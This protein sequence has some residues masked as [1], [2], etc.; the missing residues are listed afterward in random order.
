M[1][2]IGE[3]CYYVYLN[4]KNEWRIRA[5]LGGCETSCEEFWDADDRRIAVISYIPLPDDDM[6]CN[7]YDGKQYVGYCM[8]HKDI[9]KTKKHLMEYLEQLANRQIQSCTKSIAEMKKK[10]A[11]AKGMLPKY[12][13]LKDGIDL[14]ARIK[15]D[16]VY[17]VKWVQSTGAFQ[18]EPIFMPTINGKMFFDVFKEKGVWQGYCPESRLD[19]CKQAIAKAFSDEIMKVAKA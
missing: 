1:G 6:N 7:T 14:K 18:K 9:E 10:I 17:H 8:S 4:D 19:E 3:H 16:K 15:A 2:E 13:S 11:T 5:S 12:K